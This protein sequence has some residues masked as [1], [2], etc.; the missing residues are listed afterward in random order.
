[1]YQ[2]SEGHRILLTSAGAV[3]LPCRMRKKPVAPARNRISHSQGET[4]MT[5]E[6]PNGLYIAMFSIHGL[7][8]GEN[9]ELGRDADTG[10]QTLYVVE[11][12]RALARRPEV[13]RIDLLTRQIF[14]PKVDA[15]YAEPVEQLAPKGFLIRIRC[16]PRRY[17]RKEVLRP[18]LDEF[19][20]GVL[21][22][23][24]RAGRLPD[25]LHAHYADAGY[26][27]VKLSQLV[28]LPLV[29][30]GHSLGRIKKQRLLDKGMTEERILERYNIHERIEAEENALN[31]AVMVC[32]STG[33]EVQ[34]QYALYDMY[35]P[36]TMVVIPPG[37]NLERFSP[38]KQPL[39]QYPYFKEL[40]RFL[41]HPGKPMILAIA[42]PDERKNLHTLIRAYA[43]TPPLR[44]LA[45]LVLI[46]GNRTDYLE[47]EPGPRRVLRKIL[48]LI[49]RYDL[50]GHVAYPK[51]HHP[52]DIPDLYRMATLTRGV[53]V[54]PAL[55]EPFGLTLIE[56]GACGL[57]VIA[58]NDGG[59]I[60][61]LEH[62][63]NGRLIDPLDEK[64]LGQAILETLS[65]RK[66]WA[67]MARNG[68]RGVQ[69]H[70]T[71]SG[72]VQ[73]YLRHVQRFLKRWKSKPFWEIPGKKLMHTD[74]MVIT[75]IDNTL[76]GSP[77]IMAE[78]G[79]DALQELIR[80]LQQHHRKTGFA[81]ATG[82]RI[83]SAVA[84]LREWD[85]PIPDVLITSVGSEI[86]YGRDLKPDR[87]WTK[88]IHYRW[89]PERLR[90]HMAQIP[91]L[92][93]QENENQREHKLSYYLDAAVAPKI[94]D[95][96]R[97]LR[98]NHFHVNTIFSHQQFLDFLPIRA[99]K[100][101]ALWYLAQ[102]WGIPLRHFLVAGDSGNDEEM[103][104][105]PVLGVVVGNYS[106]ELESLRGR[107]AVYF[108][109]GHC[110]QGILEG[111]G[112]YSFL[113]DIR[114]PEGVP[115]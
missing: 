27:G 57:P 79:Q 15:I 7:I 52:D 28:G 56:A 51:Q 9:L 43:H 22:H 62:C 32:T 84:V 13:D 106:P 114:I 113:E 93:P 55:T 36:R 85:V 44:D 59:P 88:H 8:R 111:I 25:V 34:E 2:A 53:F 30:T 6:N 94:K 112:Y 18:Y 58:T 110:A 41:L 1:M 83:D 82:R 72:H 92:Y 3:I 86:H 107:P 16:G 97:S 69:R 96:I 61:I 24:R 17:L 98:Q 26:V 49:D 23:F 33:Q 76:I 20:E 68:L 115:A 103:L 5:G 108:A 50:Y 99:S 47:M 65:D 42:R 71:W 78:G 14:D 67:Q 95:I 38:S 46:T 10:G 19:A 74:R 104:T 12:A 37:V 77:E 100:G 73:T 4:T 89:E 90:E 54:N 39:P 109:Q 102:K 45:N 105:S 29:F 75:D 66:Q 48:H 31:T 81:I 70:Y 87:D 35:Q 64:A 63:R 40:R 60:D 91:G 21:K 101:L 80:L 11:L